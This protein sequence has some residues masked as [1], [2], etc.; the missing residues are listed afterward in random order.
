MVEAQHVKSQMRIV[1]GA[2]RSLAGSA[3]ALQSS[4]RGLTRR[5]LDGE[6]A[7]VEAWS[8]NSPTTV[9]RGISGERRPPARERRS[10]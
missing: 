6:R 5:K 2:S 3:G 8:K 4:E 1:S 9:P 7:R 10:G